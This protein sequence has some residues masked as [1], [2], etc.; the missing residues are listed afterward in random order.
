MSESK[1]GL[2]SSYWVWARLSN[3][4]TPDRKFYF[5]EK[6]LNL[7]KSDKYDAILILGASL[8][9]TVTNQDVVNSFMWNGMSKKGKS[10]TSMLIYKIIGNLAY[11]QSRSNE[12]TDIQASVTL[13]DHGKLG[14]PDL[15]GEGVIGHWWNYHWLGVM[16]ITQQNKLEVWNGAALL[17]MND[18]IW[19]GVGGMPMNN[20]NDVL[21]PNVFDYSGIGGLPTKK[22]IGFYHK[23]DNYST[24]Q[25]SAYAL[26][27]LIAKVRFVASEK[28]IEHGE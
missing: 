17:D 24:D 15:S 1:A 3:N 4:V 19:G 2:A 16:D 21:S 10:I 11:P 9:H 12:Y 14:M 22:P 18:Y 7:P 5:T 26:I 13:T 25:H 23:T 27:K 28:S 6:Y 20:D 8:N